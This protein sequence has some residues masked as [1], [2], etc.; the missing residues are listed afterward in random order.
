[1][2]AD[3]VRQVAVALLAGAI[4]WLLGQIIAPTWVTAKRKVALFVL[5]VVAVTY[6]GTNQ[7]QI[8]SRVIKWQATWR[9]V[10]PRVAIPV[11]YTEYKP[12]LMFFIPTAKRINDVYLETLFGYFP[13]RL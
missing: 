3:A 10:M 8:F 6:L 7:I 12:P 4:G 13:R 5:C 2:F 11:E 9:S 1:M